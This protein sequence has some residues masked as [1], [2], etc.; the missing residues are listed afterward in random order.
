MNRL[1][2]YGT[3]I[4][5]GNCGVIVWHLLILARLHSMFSNDQILLSASLANLIPLTAVKS[6]CGY[7]SANRGMAPPCFSRHWTADWD[8]RAFPELLSFFL[9]SGSGLSAT[10]PDSFLRSQVCRYKGTV[11]LQDGLGHGAVRVQ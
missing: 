3:L 5:L 4:V 11:A 6:C 2:I 9:R 7:V 1:P 8:L 10:K